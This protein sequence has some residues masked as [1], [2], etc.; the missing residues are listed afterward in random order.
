MRFAVS[1]EQQELRESVRRFIKAPSK[2]EIVF[3]RGTT[4][5]INLVAHCYGRQHVAAGEAVVG[6]HT[7][8]SLL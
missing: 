7:P 3:V 2:R 8:N 1:T 4:E 6:H 5:G